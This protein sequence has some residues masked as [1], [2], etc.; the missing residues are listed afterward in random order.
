MPTDKDES[1]RETP[2]RHRLP[3]PEKQLTCGCCTDGCVC[4]QH[5]DVSRG[6]PAR[7]CTYHAYLRLALLTSTNILSLGNF[8]RVPCGPDV[9]RAPRKCA[10]RGCHDS[11]TDGSE[12]CASCITDGLAGPGTTCDD[13]TAFPEPPP[14]EDACLCGTLLE[15]D[16]VDGKCSRCRDGTKILNATVRSAEIYCSQTRPDELLAHIK[17]IF[18]YTSS[19][20]IR[21]HS[22]GPLKTDLLGRLM[23]VAGVPRW[24]D[25]S[26]RTVR[27]RLSREEKLL[28]VGR[29]L[30]NVWVNLSLESTREDRQNTVTN[31]PTTDDL[32]RR[33]E[34]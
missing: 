12:F 4:H 30:E 15:G 22:T 3:R 9:D 20:R 8:A 25:I 6:I 19:N 33:G 14:S 11:R 7:A 5:Q 23:Q 21:L 26:G 2:P 17:L 28:A 34:T 32:P 13:L 18:Q 27:I 31:V 1:S 16:D 24:S 10:R 29:L